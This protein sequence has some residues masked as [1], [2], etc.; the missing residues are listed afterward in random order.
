MYDQAILEDYNR[1]RGAEAGW[2]EIVDR[3]DVDAMLFPPDEPITKGPAEAA[4]W[5]EAYRD[6]NEVV[7]LRTC[8]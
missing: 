3:Y 6:D 7:Y 1:V 5:C 8:D 2:D 4:G